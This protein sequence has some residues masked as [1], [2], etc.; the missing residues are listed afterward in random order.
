MALVVDQDRAP[1]TGDWEVSTWQGLAEAADHLG[2]GWEGPIWRERALEPEAPAMWRLLHELVAYLEKEDLAVI[3]PLDRHHVDV[4]RDAP[5][6]WDRVEALVGQAGRQ[7]GRRS[8]LSLR[9]DLGWHVDGSAVWQL[10]EPAAN[11]WLLKRLDPEEHECWAELS[12][13]AQEPLDEPSVTAGYTLPS[14]LLH[15]LHASGD[16]AGRATAAGLEIREWDDQARIVRIK[17]L[18]EF[19]E[20]SDSLA[21]QA[22]RM[23]AFAVEAISAPEALDPV[24]LQPPPT[25]RKGA[26]P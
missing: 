15:T 10:F 6:T 24:E 1:E 18:A 4:F 26:R 20:G 2:R 11:S 25:R 7:A 21:D 14:I 3:K 12:V 9:G 8:R 16:L 19:V 13:W 5:D 17:K 23:A 22:A